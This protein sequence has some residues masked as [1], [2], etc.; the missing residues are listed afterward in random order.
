MS[1]PKVSIVVPAY[2]FNEDSQKYLDLCLESIA[3][4]N[5]PKDLIDV[6]VSSSGP[7]KP[8]VPLKYRH[9]HS[10]ERLHFPKAV[11][12]G[13]RATKET[14]KFLFILN[15]DTCLTEDCLI[16]MIEVIG[17]SEMVLNPTS[18]CDNSVRYGLTIGYVKGEEFKPIAERFFRIS[19][20]GGDERL[21][22]KAQSIYPTGIIA[23]DWL[24]IYATLI[25][26]KVWEKVG[27]I[28]EKFMTGQ[29]DLD[30]CWRC[31]KL[32]IPRG[33]VLSAL[34]WHFGGVTSSKVID[35][36]IRQKNIEY[37]ISKWGQLPPT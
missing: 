17:D 6:V 31:K 23:Q 28:D 13:V 16:R 14:S 29:D 1:L 21:L 15:D 9:I 10:D 35:N 24:P 4:L 18:N 37:F 27:E 8:L 7:M 32:N 34:A 12:R 30:W 5:Y 36:P 19:D 20:M 2:F 26:R 33:V 22:I 25:P 11:N 3:A